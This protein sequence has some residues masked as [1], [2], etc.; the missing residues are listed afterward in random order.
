MKSRIQRKKFV[1][2][3]VREAVTGAKGIG[4]SKVEG[5]EQGRRTDII[6]GSAVEITA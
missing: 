2:Q 6:A 4:Q 3:D 1:T 5:V